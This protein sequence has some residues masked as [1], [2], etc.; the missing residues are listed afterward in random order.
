MSYV[1]ATSREWNTSMKERLEERTACSFTLITQKDELTLE[2]L[3]HLQPDYVFFPHW[4]Y[5]IPEKIFYHFQCII[6]HMTDVPFGRGG[7]PLQNLIA[8]GIYQTKISAL[9]CVKE[10]DAGP[11]YL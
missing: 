3:R 6:F 9:R 1:L 7:S 11:V 8:R 5:I 10:V 4:S 2:R